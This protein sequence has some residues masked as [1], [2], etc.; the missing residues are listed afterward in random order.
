MIRS[1]C[2]LEK[3]KMFTIARATENKTRKLVEMKKIVEEIK[4]NHT[5]EVEKAVRDYENATYALLKDARENGVGE[6]HSIK[7]N[8]NKVMFNSTLANGDRRAT[9]LKEIH[10]WLEANC[11]FDVFVFEYTP[12]KEDDDDITYSTGNALKSSSNWEEE[13]E[14]A[15]EEYPDHTNVSFYFQD[16]GDAMNF[17]LTWC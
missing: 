8:M 7:M 6:W 17:K 11:R 9:V 13:V 4:S 2:S 16:N 3:D 14:P 15:V 10:E 5:V 1:Q 12:T